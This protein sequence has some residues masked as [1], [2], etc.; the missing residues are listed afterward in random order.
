[1][2]TKLVFSPQWIPTQPY[3]SLPSLTAFLRANHQNVEQIDIN[4]SFYDDLLSKPGLLA[5]YERAYSKFQELESKQEL[6]PELQK[7]Y[8]TLS[9][10][11]LFSEYIIDE[12]YNAKKI[13]RYKKGFYDIE[14]L[15]RAF[16]IL[17]LGLKLASS[18]YY[19]TNLTFHSYDMRYS[20]RSSKAVLAAINDREE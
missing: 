20:C 16:K 7:Q 1:M 12:I 9:S 18:A 8:A 11:L 19:P 13:T 4:M 17:E 15:F 6:S 5:S 14:E 2:L 3:L 10:S